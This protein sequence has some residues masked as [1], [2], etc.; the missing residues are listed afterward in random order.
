[1]QLIPLASPPGLARG[2]DDHISKAR[3]KTLKMTIVIVASFI[4]CW[5]PY[6]LLGLWY[7]FQPNMIRQM[8][9]YVNHFLFLFGLLH[10]CTD[11]IIYGL[12]TPSFREDLKAC[13]RSLELTVIRKEKKTLASISEMQNKDDGERG[14]VTS[15]ASNGG[16]LHTAL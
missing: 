10:T 7:W 1:M 11:P 16:T 3:M 15:S 4:V 12:Y 5:T 6:Y 8:P 9:E 13:L 14:G 2:K